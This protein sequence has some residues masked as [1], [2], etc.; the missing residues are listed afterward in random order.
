MKIEFYVVR[1][2]YIADVYTSLED[3]KTRTKYLL[4]AYS[5]NTATIECYSTMCEVV[6]DFNKVRF[7]GRVIAFRKEYNKASEEERIK[8]LAKDFARNRT[9]GYLLSDCYVFATD[10]DGKYH[11]HGSL[12]GQPTDCAFLEGD[13]FPCVEA[14]ASMILCN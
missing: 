13:E 12:N 4:R 3:A 8:F 6:Y 14:V 11:Y 7:F 2:G 9:R 10:Y 1:S 5:P